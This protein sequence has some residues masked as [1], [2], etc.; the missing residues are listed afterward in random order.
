VTVIIPAVARNTEFE[1]V[2]PPITP[3]TCTIGDTTSTVDKRQFTRQTPTVFAGA[4]PS[5]TLEQLVHPTIPRLS[6]STCPG[7]VAVSRSVRSRHC[8]R[9][10][11]CCTDLSDTSVLRSVSNFCAKLRT[12]MPAP[13]R[14]VLASCWL[15]T[16]H[17]CIA[18]IGRTRRT[19]TL[20]PECSTRSAHL[21]TSF[22]GYGFT[23]TRHRLYYN[24]RASGSLTE[25]G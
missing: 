10:A 5:C 6:G 23:L 19:Q 2:S 11:T 17:A 12:G 21:D 22:L 14:A 24:L 1:I 7:T 25:G 15:A 13:Q 9:V 4:C 3:Y 18:L 20:I 8:K 16:V